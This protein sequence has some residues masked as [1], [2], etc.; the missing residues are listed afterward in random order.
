MHEY[1]VAYDLYA[2]SRKT[3]I[4]HNASLVKKVTV[5]LG[6]MAMVNRKQVAFLF[7]AIKENDPLFKTTRLQCEEVLPQ[8]RCSCGYTGQEIFVCPMCGALPELIKGREIVVT[9]VELEVDD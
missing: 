7:D 6:K 1:S 4:E 3:A 2:T 8:T 5:E 9:S